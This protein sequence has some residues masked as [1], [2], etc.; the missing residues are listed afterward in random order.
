[1]N[2]PPK[3]G[4]LLPRAGEATGVGLKLTDYS[5]NPNRPAGSNKAKGFESVLGITLTSID[6]LESAIGT[7]ILT[8]RIVT[9]RERPPYGVTCAVDFQLRGIG[10]KRNRTSTVRTAWILVDAQSPPRSTRA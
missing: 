5:L 2:W 6:N 4:E 3:A 8:A 7:R 1:M 10:E 9:V